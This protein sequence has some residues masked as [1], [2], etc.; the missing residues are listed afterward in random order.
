[1]LVQPP[2]I[3][4]VLNRTLRWEVNK[5]FPPSLLRTFEANHP[6]WVVHLHIAPEST[7]VLSSPA[8]SSLVVGFGQDHLHS[9]KTA[10]SNLQSAIQSS[11]NLKKLH[12]QVDVEGCG[13]Y[14]YSTDFLENGETFPPLEELVLE[15]F[16]I[17]QS[18]GE[19]WLKTMDWSHLRV[20][21]F[22]EGSFSAPFLSLLLPVADKLPALENIGLNLPSWTKDSVRE[23]RDDPNSP[24]S[25]TKQLFLT[26][27]PQSLLGVRI[28]GYYRS[29]LP[30][31][32]T[33]HATSLKSLSL[34]ET[35]IANGDQRSPLS[36]EELEEI[37]TKSAGLEALAFDV[38][39]SK[40]HTWVSTYLGPYYT[41]LTSHSSSRTTSSTRWR[42]QS[43]PH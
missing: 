41:V 36:L 35:E 18:S 21:D 25:L 26:A 23:Q 19:Y 9:D 2:D 20:L 4:K 24:F 15:W 1:M 34:H 42:L 7:G 27:R 10:L 31:I 3:T 12:L 38:N 29:L 11:K 16:Q 6:S 33:H 5:E 37:G 17:T 8:L 32:L 28:H 22:R 14:N 40:E 13:R 43:F 39:I 30:D